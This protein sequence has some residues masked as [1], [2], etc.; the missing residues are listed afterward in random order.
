L[1]TSILA[2]SC[3]KTTYYHARFPMIEKPSRPQLHNIP[4]SEMM[5]MSQPT[6]KAIAS[7]FNALIGH[8]KEYE[9]R[10]DLYNEFAAA[11]NQEL[12]LK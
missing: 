12:D 9:R 1:M 6:Q 11:K 10:V 4:A 8:E 3:C 7:N 2:S 5:K